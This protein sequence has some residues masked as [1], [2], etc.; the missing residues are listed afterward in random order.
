MMFSQ[1]FRRS[2]C[3]RPL[4][5]VAET[6]KT[7][8][9]FSRNLF[10]GKLATESKSPKRNI[11]L[12]FFFIFQALLPFPTVLDEDQK[13][14]LSSLKDSFARFL[15]NEND[16]EANDDNSSIPEKVREA[17][18]D[19]GA[20]GMMTPEEYGGLD[21]CAT[22]YASIVEEVGARDLGL[23]IYLGAHQVCDSAVKRLFI[24]T[25]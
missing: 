4:S 24:F 18:K 8:S 6:F 2:L 22:E 17:L 10:K 25:I 3:F 19:M 11:T 9:S 7:A 20:Y 14:M 21:L 13:A 12:I 1:F 15:E 23:G 16:A 5:T